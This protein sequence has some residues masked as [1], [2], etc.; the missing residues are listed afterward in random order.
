M[1]LRPDRVLRLP[2][3]TFCDAVENFWLVYSPVS[4]KGL[5]VLNQEAMTLFRLIDGKRTL[6]AIFKQAK[7][8]DPTLKFSEMA[9]IF[10]RF[11]D[12]EIIY[13]G[14]VKIPTALSRKPKSLGVWLHLTNAC[15]LRCSYCYLWKTPDRMSLKT[16]ETAIKKTFAAAVKHGLKQ[17]T[18]KFSG[19]EPLLELAKIC[20]LVPPARKLAEKNKLEVDFVILTNGTLI[21]EKIAKVLKRLRLRAAVSLDGLGTYHDAQRELVNGKGSS[22]LV[23]R[24]IMNLKKARVP[25]NVSITITHRNVKHIPNLTRYLLKHQIPF[26]FNFYRENVQ[27]ETGL[28]ATDKEL[29][30]NLKKAYRLIYDTPPRYRLIDGLLDRVS[31]KKPRLFACGMGRNY[32]VIRQD[33]QIVSCQ[34]TME[35]P[36]GSI[37]DQDLM[38]TVRQGNFVKPKNLTVEDKIPCKTCQWKYLCAGGCPLLTFS[39]KKTYIVNSPYCSV[40]RALIPELLRLEAKRLIVYGA[41]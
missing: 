12:S 3:N 26:N 7:T 8:L 31:F 23:K 35:H 1:V 2:A 15:N 24:G 18:F 22:I 28:Q 14:K 37:E 29:I 41:Q 11:L 39:K 21:T 4:E 32:L 30:E 38:A 6:R 27:A 25:F 36:I 34:M 13:F 19:G 33:G 16:A 5:A 40:Y 9:D 17:I 10:N 20:W